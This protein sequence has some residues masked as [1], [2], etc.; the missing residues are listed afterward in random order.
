M[1]DYT[2]TYRVHEADG[3]SATY[4][5]QIAGAISGDAAVEQAV[6]LMRNA[7]GERAHEVISVIPTSDAVPAPAY[8]PPIVQ[9]PI[10]GSQLLSYATLPHRSISNLASNSTSHHVVALETDY[11]L[12]RIALIKDTAG[13]QSFPSVTVAP[14][15]DVNA[16]GNYAPIDENGDPVSWTHVT[17]DSAGE[18]S[19]PLLTVNGTTEAV[20]VPEPVAN[21]GDAQQVVFDYY[22]SDWIRVRSIPRADG[23]RLPLLAIRVYNPADQTARCLMGAG[24]DWEPVNRG[25]IWLGVRAGGDHTEAAEM[26]ANT[27]ITGQWLAAYIQTYTSRR[28][29][30][31]MGVGDSLTQGLNTTNDTN[32]WGHIARDLLSTATRPVTWCNEGHGGS[33]SENYYRRAR[34]LIPVLKPHIV[35]YSP[36]SP[37]DGVSSAA[38]LDLVWS[39]G[40]DFMGWLQSQG[41]QP[42]IFGP[43]RWYPANSSNEAMRQ[44]IVQRV[45]EIEAN[46]DV[47][48]LNVDRITALA[49][50]TDTPDPRWIIGGGNTHFNDAG[51]ALLGQALAALIEPMLR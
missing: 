46:G 36:W 40:M 2:I 48:V 20:T 21:A 7:A 29:V 30:T 3:S 44:R 11:D 5:V 13:T 37:N 4:S 50:T 24:T 26:P 15:A 43:A 22:W 38:T 10:R 42:V 18:A 16:A 17:W 39:R 27:T 19:D 6:P 51:N 34:A 12:V 31:L 8:S 45:N 25:R 9:A 47:P 23:S 1:P 28:G 33:L 14:T 41:I 32:S 35:V 49:G